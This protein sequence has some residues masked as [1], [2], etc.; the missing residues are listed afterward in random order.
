MFCLFLVSSKA[1]METTQYKNLRF[2]NSLTTTQNFTVSHCSFY[3][4]YNTEAGGSIHI[5]KRSNLISVSKCIFWNSTSLGR[6]GA[7]YAQVFELII[8]SNCF[9]L[10]VGGKTNGCDGST[11]YAETE[12]GITFHEMNS[13]QSCPDHSRTTWY[14]LCIFWHNNQTSLDINVSHSTVDYSAGLAHGNSKI[15]K[16]RRYI[17]VDE[18]KG[19]AL[20]FSYQQKTVGDAIYGAFVNNSCSQG[21]IYLQGADAVVKNFVFYRNSGRILSEIQGGGCHLYDCVFDSPKFNFDNVLRTGVGLVFDKTDI[22]LTISGF[23]EVDCEK[24]GNIV[25]VA[26]DFQVLLVAIFVFLFIIGA[27]F[28][29]AQLVHFAKS[30]PISMYTTLRTK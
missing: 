1:E 15:L 12:N 29:I 4:L 21:I 6:G 16:V 28:A 30:R 17:A 18:R 14:G 23:R 7:I 8:S 24:V 10:C 19:A 9:G 20:S 25:V 5:E 13:Y 26:S 2:D 11:I 27:A 3:N 22:N